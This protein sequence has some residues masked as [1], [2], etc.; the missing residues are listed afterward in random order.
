MSY[1]FTAC[2]ASVNS[3]TFAILMWPEGPDR[4]FRPTPWGCSSLQMLQEVP[5]PR[6]DLLALL[7]GWVPQ[8]WVQRA[9][10]L[11]E[12]GGFG[13]CQLLDV[14]GSVQGRL[15]PQS[16]V[17]PCVRRKRPLKG[18]LL[19][20]CLGSY[21][22]VGRSEQSCHRIEYALK[23]EASMVE[24]CLTRQVGSGLILVC[25]SPL[26]LVKL[27]RRSRPQS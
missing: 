2:W 15:S 4:S 21:R 16:I 24:R 26:L 25:P 22:L 12:V 20:S 5:S 1:M 10:P 7:D 3:G 13:V 11:R 17:Q 19:G 6:E 18:L 8:A 27:P 23:R 14:W 9:A